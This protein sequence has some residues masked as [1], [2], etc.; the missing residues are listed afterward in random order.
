MPAAQARPSVRRFL[1]GPRPG[2]SD[3]DRLSLDT[4]AERGPMDWDGACT[5]RG[6][7]ELAARLRGGHA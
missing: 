7:L 6:L 4:L 1:R 5:D 3:L 2:T